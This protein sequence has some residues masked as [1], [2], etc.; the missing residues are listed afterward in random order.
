MHHC[1]RFDFDF[2][3]ILLLEHK[4]IYCKK[5]PAL[6]I[7]LQ[8]ETDS[9]PLNNV[10]TRN[11]LQKINIRKKVLTHFHFLGYDLYT[12]CFIHV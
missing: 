3:L 5:L 2:P 1:R 7:R 9:E 12:Y 4:L 11:Q 8:K 6:T 10:D